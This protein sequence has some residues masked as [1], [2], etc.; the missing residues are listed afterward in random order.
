MAARGRRRAPHRVAGVCCRRSWR[1]FGRKR[2]VAAWLRLAGRVFVAKERP[3]ETMD[4]GNGKKWFKSI[5]KAGEKSK[6]G[7]EKVRNRPTEP[8][9]GGPTKTGA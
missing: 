3:N 2:F 8:W 7:P 9:H 1:E 5:T 6:I 4:E